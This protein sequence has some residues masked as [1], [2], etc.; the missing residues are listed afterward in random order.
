MSG[1]LVVTG[2]ARGIGA[3]CARRAARDGWKVAVNYAHSRDAALAVVADIEREGGSAVAIGADVSDAEQA[4]RLFV[5][6]ERLFGAV[7]G[8]VNNAGIGGVVAPI[9]QQ[10]EAMMAPMFATNV[11]GYVY[12]AGAAI[13]RMS[14][15]H[16][17]KGGVIVNISSMAAKLG[18]LP[19]MVAY[20]ASKGATDSL[21]LGIAKE[22]ARDGIRVNA[23]R[24]G[25]IDT[26]ILNA[27]GREKM[28]AAVAPMVPMGRTGEPHEIAEA[29]AWLLSPAASYVHGSIVDVSG[30]R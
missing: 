7:T 28:L 10:T 26:D 29:V 2:A 6:T 4:E 27:V 24:P 30:G 25:V 12:C 15:R 17:G 21:T 14:T 23:V 18:G 1:V 22:V 13:R 9:E 16:G 5:E 11:F 3:A 8:L 20:A 19:N